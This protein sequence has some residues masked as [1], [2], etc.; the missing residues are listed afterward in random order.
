VETEFIALHEVVPKE[1][2][3]IKTVRAL[4][5]QYG[6]QYLAVKHCQQLKK[7]TQGSGG[8]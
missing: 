1:K 8:S 3:A 5:E 2:A 6:D 4:K 7:R